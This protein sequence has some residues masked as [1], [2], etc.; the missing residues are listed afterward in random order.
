[1]NYKISIKFLIPLILISSLFNCA[2]FPDKV[3]SKERKTLSMGK[4][5]VRI[6]FTG[7]YR[8]DDEKNAILEVL[9]KEGFILDPN[10]NLELEVILQKREPAYRYLWIHRLNFL[11]TFLSGGFVP[12]HIR[13]ESTLTF[14]YSNLGE[15]EKEF[16]Y[17]MGMDQWR[18]IPVVIFMITHWPNKIYKEQLIEATK[19]EIKEI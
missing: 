2:A 13:T 11:L 8:Y 10:S 7:F 16:V 3:I 5:K 9:L 4:E 17:D 18:G 14:R 19:L 1:M 6:V 12:S 15:V